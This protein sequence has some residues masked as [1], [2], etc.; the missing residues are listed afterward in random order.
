ML[1][2]SQV[3]QPP[4][5]PSRPPSPPKRRSSR[6]SHTLRL[7]STMTIHHSPNPKST[8]RRHETCFK[9][10]KEKSSNVKFLRDRISYKLKSPT[11]THK[12]LKVTK[13]IAPYPSTS[14]ESITTTTSTI[15]EPKT[16][17]TNPVKSKIDSQWCKKDH[18][19]HHYSRGTASSTSKRCCRYCSFSVP[20]KT[21]CVESNMQPDKIS[22]TRAVSLERTFG[23]EKR[24]VDLTL[25]K[26]T[27][28]RLKLAKSPDL[29]SPTEVKKSIEKQKELLTD[30][31]YPP[32][33]TI[34]KSTSLFSSAKN[35]SSKSV[36]KPEEKSLNV[37][38]AFSSKGKE[39]L[40]PKRIASSVKPA[41]P[42]L[43]RTSRQSSSPVPS[44]ISDKSK[45]SSKSRTLSTESLHSPLLKKKFT[46]S[47]PA[48]ISRLKSASTVLS[49]GELSADKN[50]KK[51]K[52]I[53]KD[54]SNEEIKKEKKSLKTKDSHV[55]NT[56]APANKV[57]KCA[58]R[59]AGVEFAKKLKQLEG[60]SMNNSKKITS[61]MIEKQQK[62][63]FQSDSFFQHLFLRDALSSPTPSISSKSSYIIEKTRMLQNFQ[64]PYSSEPTIGA[65]KVYLTHRKPVTE[66]KFKT[67]DREIIRSRS[68]SP[69]GLSR[70][71]PDHP[72]FD[73][74]SEVSNEEYYY[75][76][77]YGSQESFKNRRSSS[78]PA[79]IIFSE[80]S[81]PVSPS[82]EKNI[83]VAQYIERRSPSASPI[84]SPSRRKI[85]SIRPTASVLV[86]GKGGIKKKPIR[87]RSAGEAESLKRELA[88]A[89]RSISP[90][91]SSVSLSHIAGDPQ[92]YK[93]YVTELRHSTRKSDR[94][95][96]LNHFY[97]SL[98]RLSQLERTTSS[99]D[100]RPRR[101]FEE[102]IIDYDRWMQVRTRER[103]EQEFNNLYKKLKQ[104]QKDKDLLF[105]PKDVEQFKWKSDREFGL[106][107]KEKSVENIKEQF[108]KLKVLESPLEVTRRRLLNYDKDVYKPLWRGN[109][110]LNVVSQISEKRSQSE[111]RPV[112]TKQKLL[113]AERMLTREIGNKVWSSL[114]IEQVSAL[115]NQLAEIYSQGLQQR[116][117]DYSIT[118]DSNS[119]VNRPNTLIIRRNSATE[120]ST[121]KPEVKKPVCAKSASIGT[122]SAAQTLSES[123]KKRLSQ[124]LS[125]EVQNRMSQRRKYKSS[126]SIILGKETRGA[127]AA[128][129]ARVRPVVQ[130]S[131]TPRACYSLEPAE[132]YV[133][134][135]KAEKDFLL[136]LT[137]DK[138]EEQKADQQRTLHKWPETKFDHLEKQIIKPKKVSSTSETESAS[139]DTSTKTAIFVGDKKEQLN[140]KIEYFE[141]GTD[142]TYVPT[143]YKPAEPED[144]IDAELSEFEAI[145]KSESPVDKREKS[146]TKLMS[147]QSYADL[148]ELFGE[149]DLMKFATI[150]LSATRKQS[151]SSPKRPLLRVTNISPIRTLSET[152]SRE[153]LIR[154]RSVSPDTER[155]WNAYLSLIKGVDVRK[156]TEKFETLQDFYSNRSMGH[157]NRRCI[158]NPDLAMS[159]SRDEYEFGDV[160]WLKNR[161]ENLSRSRSRIRR[162][163]KSSPIPK[164]PLKSEDRL[165]PH[166]NII[167]KLASLYPKKQISYE[168]KQR[169]VEDLT[170]SLGCSVG[171]V[172]K[173]KDK[174][175]NPKRNVSLLGHM[176]TSSPNMH[177]LRDIAPYLAG[178]WIAHQYPRFQDNSRSAS[179]PEKNGSNK[180]LKRRDRPRPKSASPPRLAKPPS[181]LKSHLQPRRDIFANQ[182][183]NPTIHRPVCRYQPTSPKADR[184][185]SWSPVTKHTVTFKGGELSLMTDIH[186]LD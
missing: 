7:V 136:V 20:P 141:R 179:S 134:K 186:F 41:S 22:K 82:V 54:Q 182:S 152:S 32:G 185:R 92:E 118:V 151:Y 74:I 164:T 95:K 36:A 13:T 159:S 178:P 83:N 10:S 69:Y 52:K 61:E 47:K 138:S 144:D 129:E 39:L 81:R 149:R 8:T 174:F 57:K 168:E 181:I 155:F 26:T 131:E 50:K 128:A 162:H 79:K 94:F 53:K 170:K 46:A 16:L 172:E 97:S 70:S 173:L 169:S 112:S 114:S 132:E 49:E 116:K 27:D 156:I 165:M 157:F 5:P 44:N 1:S 51:T 48:M 76:N 147:S 175:E 142:E 34:K 125:R 21:S 110:V 73:S 106:K 88:L 113:S 35:G 68:V 167:S 158:S 65:L 126:V 145:E 111:P 150:P 102:E 62:D 56:D 45:T 40:N 12:S 166:I 104:E 60:T 101:R 143:I 86:E 139:S 107:V 177:E 161:F 90:S 11:S 115:K 171:E 109:S 108:E 146:S 122:L 66:S 63:I 37:T 19:T 120:L 163:G 43:S 24:K 93:T 176:F 25:P 55:K 103:A 96:E 85:N 140:K 121:K 31:H 148:K 38:V 2:S 30:K 89:E 127:I 67:L 119:K 3:P 91:V 98:E 154:S 6:N 100:L 180:P 42:T 105:K 14:K 78:L 18:S 33:T 80:T 64:T 99:T 15:K 71:Y 117:D 123:E 29:T 58:G 87:A 130:E 77:R 153:S 135:A 160:Y 72:R 183:Y 17:I 23:T 137:K 124:S 59:A 28:F 133:N 75:D 184:S 84:R 9:S 4:R